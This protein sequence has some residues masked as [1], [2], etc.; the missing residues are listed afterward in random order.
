[1]IDVAGLPAPASSFPF[2]FPL[3]VINVT[4]VAALRGPEQVVNRYGGATAHELHVLPS[5]HRQQ[6]GD[7][8]GRA[9]LIC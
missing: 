9:K 1:M 7:H 5:Q 2:A 4:T 3:Y 6:D 8:I